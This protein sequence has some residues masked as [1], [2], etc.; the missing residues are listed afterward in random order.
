MYII[1]VAGSNGGHNVPLL[2]HFIIRPLIAVVVVIIIVVVT[3]E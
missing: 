2:Y 1:A 3:Y